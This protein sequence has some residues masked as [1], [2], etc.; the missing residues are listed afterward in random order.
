MGVLIVPEL[1]PGSTSLLHSDARLRVL[2]EHALDLIAEVDEADAV[3]YVSP[4]VTSHLGFDPTDLIGR[5]VGEF[6]HPEDRDDAREWLRDAFRGESRLVT[7][8][9]GTSAGRWPHYEVS[10]A[11]FEV[12]GTRR[13]VIVCRNVEERIR[14]RSMTQELLEELAN[15][16]LIVVREPDGSTRRSYCNPALARMLGYTVEEIRARTE[17][18]LHP[19][20]AE[21]AAEYAR[22]LM[23]AEG[24]TGERERLRLLHR[25]GSTVWVESVGHPY[26][27]DGVR[28]GMIWEHRD[29]TAEVEAEQRLEA[30]E[31]RYRTLVEQLESGISLLDP[32]G[33][34]L[35]VNQALAD[36]LGYD[37]PAGYLA[38][39]PDEVFDD[40]VWQEVL[41]CLSRLRAGEDRIEM[42]APMR[43]RDES[44]RVVDLILTAVRSRGE[45]TGI[46]AE[47]RD[48]T[49]TLEAQAR[50]ES[51]EVLHRTMVEQLRVGISLL[52]GSGHRIAANEAMAEIAGCSLE[53]YLALS[54]SDIFSDADW[55]RLL[56]MRDRVM[57]GAERDHARVHMRRVDSTLRTVDIDVTGIRVG[58]ELTTI[59]AEHRDVTSQ[60]EAQAR[61]EASEELHRTL[62][63]FSQNGVA[64]MDAVGHR[65]TANLA[66]AT[67]LG[68]D[69]VDEYMA[70]RP[71]EIIGSDGW[72][73][74]L[75]MRERL[76]QGE[77]QAHARVGMR[78]KDGSTAII[79]IALTAIR[80]DGVLTGFM[81]D[82]RDVT[83]E[84]EAQAQLAESEQRY[85]ILIDGSQN[86]IAY[87]DREGHRVA[88]NRALASMVGFESIDEYMAAQRHEII[89]DEDWATI[90]TLRQ[91]II[92][93][94]ESCS[95]RV[96]MRHR[97]G[98]LVT[99]DYQV[100]A[101]RVDGEIAGFI[102]DHR[103][104]TAQ[105]EAE[106]RLA[107]SEE[108][109]RS[110]V[111]RSRN[112]IVLI[113]PADGRPLHAN[114]AHARM[115]GYDSPEEALNAPLDGT[116]SEEDAAKLPQIR[117]RLNAGE[118]DVITD[119][120]RMRRR[121]GG[122]AVAD[123]SFT[124]IRDGGD[125]EITGILVDHLDLTNEIEAA[126]RL[127]ESERLYR[128][129]IERSQNGITLLSP[130]GHRV[131]VNQALADM[132]GYDTPE[133]YMKAPR[134]A[135]FP[136]DEW[137]GFAQ[138]LDEI[139]AGSD[140]VQRRVRM[141][142][143]DGTWLIAE[144]QAGPI[145]SGEALTGIITECRDVTAEEEARARI[146]HSE[147]RYRGLFERSQNGMVLLSPQMVPLEVNQ[148]MAAMLGRTVEEYLALPREA[149]IV[150]EDEP[151]L[152]DWFDS[153]LAN[154]DT[155]QHGRLRFHHRDG[156]YI[157]VDIALSALVEDGEVV[158]VIA[159]H[160]D[161]TWEVAAR[162]QL[163]ESEQR[164][165]SLLERSQNGVVM[166]DPERRPLYVNP[167]M[168]AMLGYTTDEYMT[169]PRARRIH[170][171]DIAGLDAQFDD[172]VAN[173]SQPQQLRLRF[174]HRDGH[175]VTAEVTMSALMDGDRVIGAVSDHRD[176][177]AEL[178]AA[179]RLE[180]SERR[181]RALFEQAQNGMVAVDRDGTVERVN[182]AMAA[183][184]GYSVE[185]YLALTLDQ[186]VHPDDIAALAAARQAAID[187]PGEV[188]RSQVRLLHREPG[189]LVISRVSHRALMEGE[190]VVGVL[191]EHRDVT[192]EVLAQERL[193]ASEQQYRTLFERSQGGIAVM[194][195]DSTTIQANEALA[196]MLGYDTIED[197]F[198][199]GREGRIH[200]D[201]VALAYEWF[202]RALTPPYEPVHGRMRFTHRE[203]GRVVLIDV[204][205]TALLSGSEP[206][207]VLAEHRDVTAEV[208][209]T[210]GLEQSEQRYRALIELVPDG[211]IVS[212][213]TGDIMVVNDSMCRLLGYS[214]DELL[215]MHRLDIVHPDEV[216]DTMA[217][218]E[219]RV[220]GH[221]DPLHVVR[222]LV[223]KNGSEILTNVT[224]ISMFEG[225][226][227]IGVMGIYT[228]VTEL[229]QLE[230]EVER[231]RERARRALVRE[232]FLA[233]MSHELRTPL[234]S[235]LGFAEL[236]DLGMAGELEERQRE[237][238]GEISNAGE[239]LLMLI[240]DILDMSKIDAG[241][242]ALAPAP[243]APATLVAEV[244]R[245]LEP[246]ARQANVVVTLET[247]QAPA[248]AVVDPR[249]F[250]QIVTNL[251]A[252]AVK[253]S[254]DGEVTVSLSQRDKDLIMFVRD[255]GVGI[256]PERLD[257]VFEPFTQAEA[258]LDRHFGGTG[259]GLTIATRLVEVHSGQIMLCS[260]VGEGTTIRVCLPLEPAAEDAAALRLPRG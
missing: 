241:K 37:S 25:D 50:L 197:Y 99:V 154:P 189:R 128:Q 158:G 55:A 207:A 45:L 252:N 168:A 10:A 150:L 173:P 84:M 100:S 160:R 119:R 256:P 193:E 73:A 155:V 124:A 69:S 257:L 93:G 164:L 181:Y 200:Q 24:A 48:V 56:E 172:L 114:L 202:E 249:G 243:V 248:V 226:T 215:A 26:I 75:D 152:Q 88:V 46:V 97:E 86:G 35:T 156:H 61:L 178:R 3:T 107:S 246:V 116:F 16:V 83:A 109:Y 163:E 87:L 126:E 186:R 13:A 43:H 201:D 64:L 130:D 139:R 145:R 47:H 122:Y 213:S 63:Q 113:D 203:P 80:V 223:H 39:E 108:R 138:I 209:A 143:R 94:A 53:E 95:T 198:E 185:E 101:L 70:T 62:V 142:R 111:E 20:D 253:F 167:A 54:P 234:T 17:P 98:H 240:N 250:R 42:R 6:V 72:T 132:L 194:D 218:H 131:M 196:S 23:E 242:L 89:S 135:V 148:A 187:H 134:E 1:I 219:A 210:L 41:A 82:H 175:E 104:V 133:E 52:D 239:Q 33:R 171:D 102:S 170:P 2:A 120:F 14:A 217:L 153:A 11:T 57:E 96:Q 129:L 232:E 258:G 151:P 5:A 220:A 79:D 149:R 180:S 115:L 123:L 228:D 166:I 147:Q 237:Y 30:S 31:E 229:A 162:A 205:L 127:A 110:L 254:R 211:I 44:W 183:M 92:D 214:R 137:P 235:I 67:M 38:A 29:I 206:I 216:A 221:H 74:L 65:V 260:T 161:V 177:T 121:D 27:E 59:L 157:T 204:M 192:A 136:D 169:V 40:D 144:L 222:R 7:V 224:V 112:G 76:R 18:L 78:R 19:D 146:E 12:D 85:R 118:S 77:D 199:A 141:L 106:A 188:Q 208:E 117:A 34:R 251:L 174:I 233:T 236:L 9:L 66:L 225:D 238:V 159:E 259:L 4:A 244:V 32:E 105:V 179:Q 8:R 58:G 195:L 165:R 227:F 68:F 140:R 176:I 125:G 22:R 28:R 81:S 71:S 212:D 184:Q 91:Q 60:L 51:S 15:G 231:Q 247:V 90:Q 245:S 255:T 103:D 191:V 190:Q 49:A 21:R 182:D 230:N 36:M